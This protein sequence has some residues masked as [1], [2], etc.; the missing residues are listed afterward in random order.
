MTLIESEVLRRALDVFKNNIFAVHLYYIVYRIDTHYSNNNC[1]VITLPDTFR[2]S[3]REVRQRPV[4]R[5]ESCKSV[6]TEIRKG[7]WILRDENNNIMI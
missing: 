7:I 6:H 4:L 3:V 5:S 2:F 1:H